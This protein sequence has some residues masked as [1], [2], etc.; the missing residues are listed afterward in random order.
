MKKY[1][2]L[3]LFAFLL[4]GCDDGDLTVQ[5]IDFSTVEPTSCTD[6]PNLMYKLKSQEAFLLQMPEGAGLKSEPGTY[7]YDIPTGGNGAYRAI[8][9]SYDGAVV[10]DNICGIIP[11]SKPKVVDEWIAT[12][13]KITI[14]TTQKEQVPATDGSTKLTGYNHNISFTNI[15]FDI[16]NSKPQTYPTYPF[17]TIS[18]TMDVPASLAFNTEIAGRCTNNNL[19]RVYNYSASFYISIDNIDSDLIKNEVTPAGQPRTG[20]IGATK[21]NAIVNKVYYRSVGKDTGS[22]SADYFCSATTP[23]NPSIAEDWSGQ[24]GVDGTSGIIEVTT[25]LV[26]GNYFHEITLKN[27]TMLKGKSSFKLPTTFNL[28]RLEIAQ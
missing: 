26:A 20:L 28:G 6:N 24:D 16:S 14:T 19:N 23:T 2:S 13:G 25:T 18:T 4:N 7:D 17:G 12:S 5:E 21:N 11:P 22:F 15:T 1:A 9:R 10:S 3:I 27:V 8:Y